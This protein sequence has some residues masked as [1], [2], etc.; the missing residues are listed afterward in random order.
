MEDIINEDL[1]FDIDA[2][3]EFNKELEYENNRLE[4]Q[5]E[6]KEQQDEDQQLQD[7]FSKNDF[8]GIE[9]MAWNWSFWKD[10]NMLSN[11]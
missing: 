11:L 10:N 5:I 6:D 3:L 1:E 2:D 7:R 9:I 4:Y 8:C